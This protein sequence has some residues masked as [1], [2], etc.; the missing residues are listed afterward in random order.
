MSATVAVGVATQTGSSTAA[1]TTPTKLGVDLSTVSLTELRQLLATGRLSSR[2]LTE[3]YVDRIRLLNSRGPSLNAVRMLNP[4]AVDE[5]KASDQRLKKKVPRG[6]LEGVPILLKDNID[7]RGLP[8]TAGNVALASS[9]PADDAPLVSQLREAGAVILGKTNL[10]EFANFMTQGANPSGYSSLGGQVLNPYDASQTP[11]GSSSGSGVAMAVGMAAATVGT[12]T[13]GSILSPSNANSVV[14]IKP[15]VGLISRTGV[16]PISATQDT[17]GPMTRSVADAAVMLTAMAGDDPEDPATAGGPAPSTDYTKALSKT[18]LNGARI[19]FFQATRDSDPVYDASLGK[20]QDEGAMLVP[21]TISTTG[22]PPS[23]LGYEFKRD[24]NA[25]LQRLP[26][27]APRKSMQ[28]ILE[29][30]A[31]H[32]D[33][34][35]KFGQAQ[36][37]ESQKLDVSPGSADTAKYGVD[38]E[39]GINWARQ[40]IDGALT[41]DPKD[42][43]DDLVAIAYP[44]SGSA[45]I[46]ARAL[47]PSIVV[48]A[49]YTSTHR[50]P[51]GLSFLGT[52]FSEATLIGL[53]YDFEQATKAWRPPAVVNPSLFRGAEQQAPGCA[54]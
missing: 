38:K 45:G 6:P 9:Y 47:Y 17:A 54:P 52:A 14:G 2:E 48:P 36:F 25:Y 20:L 23:I 12:E 31:A 5:A 13:S 33:V 40:R 43:S 7:V 53:A 51:A 22:Q 24:L 10:S 19:G 11:S 35:L 15:T 16:I 30:N 49:G 27:D 39:D 1:A 32:A 44:N 42:A 50:R 8:T 4:N 26:A 34:A 37:V 21:V 46:G 18:A 29:Y 41:G 28:D 3:S